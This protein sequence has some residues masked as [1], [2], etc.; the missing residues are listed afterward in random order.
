MIFAVWVM[1]AVFLDMRKR[2]R[3]ALLGQRARPIEREIMAM[4]RGQLGCNMERMGEALKSVE[5]ALS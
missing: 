4:T 3:H 1:A 2:G 5:P